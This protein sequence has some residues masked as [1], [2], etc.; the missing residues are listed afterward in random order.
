MKQNLK[1]QW[2]Q[3]TADFE[4]ILAHLCG[5]LRLPSEPDFRVELQEYV[6]FDEYGLAFEMLLEYLKTTQAAIPATV[7][8]LLDNLGTRMQLNR[9]TW[10]ELR[11]RVETP[12]DT[13]RI[14]SIVDIPEIHALH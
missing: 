10:E 14:E 13:L 12:D 9:D 5:P 8:I 2:M 3:N 11:F 7:Y 4:N 6:D 1:A